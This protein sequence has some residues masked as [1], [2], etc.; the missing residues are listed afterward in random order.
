[1]TLLCQCTREDCPDGEEQKKINYLRFG[2]ALDLV[3]FVC[4]DW[5]CRGDNDER[6]YDKANAIVDFAEQL[7]ENEC[8]HRRN[9][10]A[11][12]GAKE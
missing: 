1:M 3:N 2:S 8:K 5:D 10:D 6:H 4:K 11:H 7:A 9:S 12:L